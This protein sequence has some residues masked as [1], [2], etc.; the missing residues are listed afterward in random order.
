MSTEA[1]QEYA[2]RMYDTFNAGRLAGWSHADRALEAGSTEA[3]SAYQASDRLASSRPED[4]REKF[5]SGF[6]RGIDDR[7]GLSRPSIR[8]L[9]F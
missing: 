3:E 9:R 6:Y 8:L 5:I 4:E 7:L 2:L 1:N